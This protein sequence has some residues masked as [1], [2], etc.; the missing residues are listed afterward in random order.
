MKMQD[1]IIQMKLSTGEEIV[2]TYQ[3]PTLWKDVLL[4]ERTIYTMTDEYSGDVTGTQVFYT[5]RSWLLHALDPEQ[6]VENRIVKI[7]PS[8]IIGS[9]TPHKSTLEQYHASVA[10]LKKNGEFRD[11]PDDGN[12]LDSDFDPTELSDSDQVDTSLL[13]KLTKPTLLN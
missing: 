10:Q 8:L 9:A 4:I 3:A 1:P 13:R 11:E 2:A 5:M 6:G 7:N 12:E